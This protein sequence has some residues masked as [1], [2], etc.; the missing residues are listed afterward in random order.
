LPK[1]PETKPKLSIIQSIENG[2]TDLDA[3]IAQAIAD[4]EEVRT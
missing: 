1:H 4:M 2:V 3:L